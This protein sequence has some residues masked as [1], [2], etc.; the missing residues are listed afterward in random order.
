[1]SPP[2]PP[3]YAKILYLLALPPQPQFTPLPPIFLATLPF[4]HTADI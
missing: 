3:F 2:L 4:I 1:M